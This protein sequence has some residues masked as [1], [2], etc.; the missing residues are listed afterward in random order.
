MKHNEPS[1]GEDNKKGCGL[2]NETFS[3]DGNPSICKDG[4]ILCSGKITIQKFCVGTP[5]VGR[6]KKV[7]LVLA[8]GGAGKPEV[9]TNLVNYLIGFKWNSESKNELE[10][11]LVQ[12]S[13][14][15][16]PSI[17]H[18]INIYGCLHDRP[19]DITIVDLP[20]YIESNETTAVIRYKQVADIIHQLT[21]GDE[22]LRLEQVNA[23]LIVQKYFPQTETHHKLRTILAKKLE[24]NTSNFL[25]FSL[26]E[27]DKSDL[28]ENAINN[29][30]VGNLA[31]KNCYFM[32]LLI[33]N[34][35]YTSNRDNFRDL[36][37]NHFAEF[38]NFLKH[39]HQIELSKTSEVVEKRSNLEKLLTEIQ[40]K[41]DVFRS[42]S[43]EANKIKCTLED[44]MN[45]MQLKGERAVRCTKC[46]TTCHPQCNHYFVRTCVCMQWLSDVRGCRVCTGNCPP[47]DHILDCYG[48]E[49]EKRR[50]IKKIEEQRSI[51]DKAQ[52]DLKA[53]KED[54]QKVAGVINVCLQNLSKI[55]IEPTVLSIEG[56]LI[57]ETASKAKERNDFLQKID[58]FLEM[59]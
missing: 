43:Y 41:I 2:S 24:N 27:F 45:K 15:K 14:S 30:F 40:S 57:K 59:Q 51:A 22:E 3:Q 23:V 20:E 26:E 49:E 10:I 11:D 31:S 34:A 13:R 47:S 37:I 12:E 17:V 38:L 16:N 29:S 33:G 7:I 21:E 6:A 5:T 9:V 48:G 18:W 55:A 25:T 32:P 35:H 54:V 36:A 8:E 52:T 39:C 4:S 44:P 1:E 28:T 46:K 42:K 53:A 56:D 19:F 58:K 50:K